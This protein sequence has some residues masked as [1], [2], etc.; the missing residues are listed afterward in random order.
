MN[1]LALMLSIVGT[2]AAVIGVAV[3]ILRYRK[4]STVVTKTSVRVTWRL[5]TENKNRQGSPVAILGTESRLLLGIENTSTTEA[6]KLEIQ[7]PRRVSGIQY[8]SMLQER[9]VHLEPGEAKDIHF[10]II[11]EIE[12][13]INLPAPIIYTVGHRSRERLILPEKKPL[14]LVI[15]QPSAPHLEVSRTITPAKPEVYEMVGLI[16]HLENQG[17]AIAKQIT[18]TPPIPS[19]VDVLDQGPSPFIC[20]GYGT[21]TTIVYLKAKS[22][23]TMEFPNHEITYEDDK[24]NHYQCSVPALKLDVSFRPAADLLGRDVEMGKLREAREKLTAGRGQLIL[25]PGEAGA[26][27]SRLAEE[28]LGESQRHGLITVKVDCTQMHQ[29]IPFLPFKILLMQLQSCIDTP[30]RGMCTTTPAEVQSID[31]FGDIRLPELHASTMPFQES[32]LGPENVRILVQEALQKVSTTKSLIVCLEDIHWCDSG[33]LDLVEFLA[34]RL[35]EMPILL[36]GTYRLEALALSEQEHGPF[37]TTL[38]YLRQR[39]LLYELPPLKLFSEKQ[40]Q[41]FIY[42]AFP[43]HAFPPEISNVLYEETGGNPLFLIEVLELLREQGVIQRND[44]KWYMTKGIELVRDTIPSTVE[45]VIRLRLDHLSEEQRAELE[46]ASIFGK[47]FLFPLWHELSGRPEDDLVSFIDQYM[48]YQLVQEED[49]REER[50]TFT[51]A[52]IQE[53]VYANIRELRRRRMHHK[54]AEVLEERQKHGQKIDPAEIAQHYYRAA[55]YGAALPYLIKAGGINNMVNNTYEARQNLRHAEECISKLGDA[56]D[57]RLVVE[58]YRT[59]GESFVNTGDYDKAKEECARCIELARKVSNDIQVAWALNML[60]DIERHQGNYAQSEEIYKQCHDLAEKEG[61][62]Y[63]LTEIAKDMGLLLYRRGVVERALSQWGTATESFRTAERFLMEALHRCEG[64]D[65][66]EKLRRGI[67][68]QAYNYLGIIKVTEGHYGEAEEYY[69]RCEQLTKRYN[70]AP[71]V[72]NSYGELRRRQGRLIEAKKHYEAFLDYASR[73]GLKLEQARAYNN[74]GIVLLDQ[75]DLDGAH[76]NFDQSLELTSNIGVRDTRIETLIMKG[77]AWARQDEH[78]KALDHYR[79]SLRLRAESQKGSDADKDRNV[80]DNGTAEEVYREV[81]EELVARGEFTK[82][83]DFL[84]RCLA[85]A[86]DDP[87]ARQ[88]LER[89]R[90]IQKS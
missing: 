51:H 79:E 58:F 13:K 89:C 34:P 56:V 7:Q 1:S 53:V 26:G 60:A 45:A 72:Q 73:A 28:F 44:D 27:K 90:Q 17:N 84:E 39:H 6:V 2:T 86:P 81:G 55:N 43:Q 19:G 10:H 20:P 38:N 3:A 62:N 35:Q 68:R 37:S 71:Y 64:L 16:Y 66:A 47:R 41:Q 48:K 29:A 63:L 52:K 67:E 57:T 69:D 76:R 80:A 23:G 33:S 65:V 49:P 12:G 14:E 78:E 40:T 75:G 9:C 22:D 32:H 15:E 50:F 8:K 24:G 54:A 87:K 30:E 70:L 82:A 85:T 11:P 46:K 31:S 18:I 4:D 88:L 42:S 25:I 61:D 36:I 77:I 21:V 83:Q 74:L 5:A 59:R